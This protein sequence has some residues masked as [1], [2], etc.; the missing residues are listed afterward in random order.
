[1]E[2]NVIIIAQNCTI[3]MLAIISFCLTLHRKNY[4]RTH[5]VQGRAGNLGSYLVNVESNGV[6]LGFLAVDAALQ[7]GPRRPFNF[8]GALNQNQLDHLSRLANKGWSSYNM[9]YWIIAF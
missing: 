6:N 8:V 4:F 3:L 5:S 2:P 7:P 9:S 1:M